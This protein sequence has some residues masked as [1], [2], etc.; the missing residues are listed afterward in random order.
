MTKDYTVVCRSSSTIKG[1]VN[2]QEQY[3]TTDNMIQIVQPT[4]YG[5]GTT[6]TIPRH[7]VRSAPQ[8]TTKTQ[9]LMCSAPNAHPTQRR[10]T[11]VLCSAMRARRAR[12][13]T[14][15]QGRWS[16]CA[17][18]ARSRARAESARRAAP[19]ASRPR[20]PTSTRTGS[21]WRAGPAGPTTKW[22]PSATA[23]T[24]S[25]AA[26]ARPTA[27]RPLGARGWTPASVTPATS[28]RGSCAWPAQSARPAR[29]TTTTAS[30]ARCAGLGL[31]IL[32]HRQRAIRVLRSAH[33]RFVRRQYTTFQRS[34]T[35][36]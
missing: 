32:P 8:G 7:F 4:G 31:L 18:W 30:A 16:A 12:R 33:V 10:T 20:A 15:A 34:Q 14:G 25:L 36:V 11:P 1:S 17:T 22:P 28:C 3:P 27:G 35:Q 6:R 23:R 24:T 29:Q 5:L 21:A 2:R 19:G 26:R 9:P 13:R